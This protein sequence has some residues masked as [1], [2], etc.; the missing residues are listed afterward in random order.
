MNVPHPSADVLEVLDAFRL[1]DISGKTAL[2]T[3]GA[4]G[5]GRFVAEGFVRAGVKVYIASRNA[6]Q[7]EA[8][9]A[10]L[11]TRGE[12][13]SLAFDLQ[14]MQ[15]VEGLAAAMLEQ[16]PSLDILVNNS[17]S[18]WAAPLD[19]FPEQGWDDVMDLNLKSPFFLTQ[20]L[21]PALRAAGVEGDPARVIN[22]GSI[23]GSK[24]SKNETFSYMASKSALHHLTAALANRLAPDHITVNA[25]APGAMSGGMMVRTT[26]DAEFRARISAGIPLGRPGDADDLAG[27]ANFLCSRAGAYLTGVVIPLDG[28]ASTAA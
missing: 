17:G 10:E 4:R 3:G 20:K 25:I 26:K 19:E 9:A 16:E 23:A 27:V 5:I 8:T 21:L 15:G 18:F 1:F 13:V 12:C 6:E 11:S 22:I 2:V 7:G 28:G 14:H 24:V